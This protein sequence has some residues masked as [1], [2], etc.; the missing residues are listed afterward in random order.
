MVD[1]YWV[2]NIMYDKRNFIDRKRDYHVWNM[3][4]LEK[5]WYIVDC[6]MG[7]LNSQKSDTYMLIE[8][9]MAI[10]L[11]HP[12]DCKNQMVSDSITTSKFLENAYLMS[13][14]YKIK[15]WNEQNRKR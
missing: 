15:D 9:Y 7:I 4:Y 12:F 8:P 1:G 13:S 3:V 6:T 14:S 2:F 5:K 11:Y 10:W